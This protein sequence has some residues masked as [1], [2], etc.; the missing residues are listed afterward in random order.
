MKTLFLISSFIVLSCASQ[1]ESGQTNSNNMEAS[2]D[3]FTEMTII[4]SKN[5]SCEF[6]LQDKENNLYE[7]QDISEKIP[8]IKK[9]NKIWIKYTSLRKMSVCEAQPIQIDEVY[10]EK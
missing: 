5:I 3:G 1:S 8:A 7:I 9:G 2:K 10:S 6:L 4:A